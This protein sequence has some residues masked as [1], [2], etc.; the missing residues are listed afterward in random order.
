MVGVAVAV[1]VVPRGA[2]PVET[3][4]E[5]GVGGCGDSAVGGGTAGGDLLVA[6][7]A[8]CANTLAEAEAEALAVALARSSFSS[9]RIL[10]RRAWVAFREGEWGV[11][12]RGSWEGWPAS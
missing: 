6:A 12:G 3:G 8:A 1:A 7:V 11:V 5:G 4:V 10:D 2:P 9:D